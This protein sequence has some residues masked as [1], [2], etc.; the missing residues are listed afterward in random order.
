MFYHIHGELVHTEPTF[1]VIDCGG[2]GYKLTI[3][4]STFSSL[5]FS[6][7]NFPGENKKVKLFTHLQVREDGIELFGFYSSE[8]LSAFKLLTTVS[9]VGPKAAMSIL[10]Q[11]SPER[12]AI[13]VTTEDT[14]AISKAQGVGAKTAAR[15]VLELKEK[16]AKEFPVISNDAIIA[17]LKTPVSSKD[18]GKLADAQDA[19]IV[20]GYTRAE[21]ISVLKESDLSMNVDEIIKSALS[22]LSKLT[23]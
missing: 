17:D 7:E 19:L 12:F 8:E 5:P 3:S 18:R 11:L 21:A 10:S 4:N 23:K 14:K 1:A 15:I 22:K 20:L 6:G 9:G 16:V 2:V 13:A